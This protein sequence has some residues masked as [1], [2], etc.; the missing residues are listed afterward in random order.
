MLEYSPKI[1]ILYKTENELKD[2]MVDRLNYI[3]NIKIHKEKVNGISD[4]IKLH[5]IRVDSLYISEKL[6]EL[7]NQDIL[8]DVLEPMLNVSIFNPKILWFQ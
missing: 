1:F 3:S 5:G 7:I 4:I 2:A 6:R 8:L